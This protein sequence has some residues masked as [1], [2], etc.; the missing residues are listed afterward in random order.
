IHAFLLSF[1]ALIFGIHRITII[2]YLVV[3]VVLS[4]FIN[5]KDAESEWKDGD[6]GLLFVWLIATIMIV[7]IPFIKVGEATTA[8]FAYRAY[9]NAD[10]FRNMAV[11]GSLSTA[12]IPPDN[13][14]LAGNPLHY[15]WFF[16]LLPAFWSKIIPSYRA[17][18]LLVQFSIVSA[19]MFVAAL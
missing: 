14:Y 3:A 2:I 17:D 5:R 1:V 6:W 10:F 15:Y 7:S 18:F 12:G 19:L 4:I 8:G 9:F 16:H 11:A 13:P